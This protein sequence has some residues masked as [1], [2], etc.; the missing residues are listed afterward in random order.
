MDSLTSIAAPLL[1]QESEEEGEGEEEGEE[2]DDA[3]KPA[4][5]DP[6]LRKKQLQ[7]LFEEIET[8]YLAVISK[9]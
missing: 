7:E 1:R 3:A 4:E 8:E 2:R 9:L 5:I 6:E